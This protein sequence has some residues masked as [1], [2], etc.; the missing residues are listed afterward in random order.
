MQRLTAFVYYINTICGGKRIT[1]TEWIMVIITAIYVITTIFICV[2]NSRAAKAAKDQVTEIRKQYENSLQ[3]KMLPYLSVEKI[4]NE[5]NTR[6]IISFVFGNII[7][8]HCIR[9]DFYFK[10]TN[11][12]HDIAKEIEYTLY[13][14]HGNNPHYRVFS[15]PVN[16]SRSICIQ[17][18]YFRTKKDLET[19]YSDIQIKVEYNDL[20]DNRYMQEFVICFI[21]SKEDIKLE[22]YYISTPKQC[23]K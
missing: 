12:G 2:Y 14:D 5:P 4:E 21:L 16:E 23:Q 1:M 7:D 3:I 18:I 13:P 22:T 6:G 20:F 11:V 9:K 10:V 17:A 19:H 8:T 15:L